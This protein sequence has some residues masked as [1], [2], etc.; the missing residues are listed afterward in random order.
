MHKLKTYEYSS[1]LRIISPE[2]QLEL[3]YH[4]QDSLQ[5]SHHDGEKLAYKASK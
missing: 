1:R 5:D 2:L 3:F 4:M